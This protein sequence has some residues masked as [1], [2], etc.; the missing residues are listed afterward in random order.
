MDQL[1]GQDA[2]FLYM[3]SDDGPTHMTSI[4]VFDPATSG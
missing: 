2:Q 3:E 1:S 4:A